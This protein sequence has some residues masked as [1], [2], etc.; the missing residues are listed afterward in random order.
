MMTQQ[1]HPR[2][3]EEGL[4]VIFARSRR[5]LAG[6][7]SVALAVLAGCGGPSRGL[8]PAKTPNDPDRPLRLVVMDPLS[9]QLA[10]ACV[11]G[12]A[13]RRYGRLGEFLGK[14]LGRKVTV[15][16]AESL[17]SPTARLDDGADL[18]IGKFS[19]VRFDAAALSL[20][21]T[22]IAMLTGTDGKVTQTGLF[23]V[24]SK[25]AAR[26]VMDLK[27][28]KVL[29]GP[30]ESDEKHAAA[31]ATLEAFALPTNGKPKISPGC[32]TAAMAVA[33]KEADAAVI[34][35][36]ALPLLEGCGNIDKGA[37]RVLYRTDPVPFIGVF[38]TG[39]LDAQERKAVRQALLAVR[40]D[41]ALLKVM[42]SAAGF[43]ALDAPATGW[44]DWRGPGR[45]AHSPN[46]PDALPTKPPLLWSHTLTGGSMAGLAVQDGRII[47]ADKSLD[48]QSDVWRCLDADTGRELWKL[49][50]AA[51]GKMD[52]TNTARANPVVHGPL[53]YLLGAFGHLHC[54]RLSDG[55]V[56]WKKNMVRDFGA[57]LPQWGY[58]G[59]PLI[60]DGRLIVTP[61]APKASIAA[62]DLQTG[63]V[64]WKTPGGPPGY[65]SF[66][67]ARLGGVTQVVGHDVAS[68]GGWDPATGKRLWKLV[69]PESDDFNVPTPIV[70]AQRLL[71]STE[72]NGTR[73]YGFDN[74]GRI[75]PK[76]VA[77]TD[78]L[79]PDTSTPVVIDDLVF[80]SDGEMACLDLRAG[81]KMLWRTNTFPFTDYCTFIAG[82]GRVLVAT[83]AGT[84]SL[85]KADR[86]AGKMNCLSTV[87]LFEDLSEEERAIWSHPAVVGNRLYL[88]NML[89]VYC[90]L[91]E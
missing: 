90:F 25:D 36:Y 82:N 56:I 2:A 6:L 71:V 39:T 32:S 8:A 76:P 49:A 65:G 52:F 19:V 26:S 51:P 21:I 20:P 31:L 38:A 34:S 15:A 30:A 16:Y 85:V 53:A 17:S 68:L 57:K 35:S 70:V 88:R 50:Y 3:R 23:V 83:T 42:E 1:D 79:T 11:G 13:Q 81:L 75:V 29:F 22:P 44:T 41:K 58:C 64:L 28:R 72:N 10:C 87:K 24:R 55:K 33:E 84:V 78:E 9:L 18:I 45:R 91:L 69:P 67:L 4:E 80:G 66:V 62:L 47:T 40:Q 61:G 5:P 59:T 86:A 89:G 60:A 73:L 27:G 43:V 77:R 12:Y 74:R 48:G 63:K 7:L 14:R 46:L 37:L 54:V